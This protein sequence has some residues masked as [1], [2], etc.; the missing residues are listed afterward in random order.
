MAELRNDSGALRFAL[1]LVTRETAAA[2]PAAAGEAAGAPAGPPGR[3]LA[4]AG[5]DYLD[6]RD[7]EWWP[8]V[9][10][11][12]AWLGEAAARQLLDELAQLLRGARGG[13]AW[14]PADQAGFAVQ[15][16]AEQ[17]GAVLEVGIDLGAFLADAAGVTWRPEA[18]LALFRFR[19][20]QADLVRF[21]DALAR[22]LEA[23]GR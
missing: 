3:L 15:V 22:E 23:T 19:A 17:G 10:L 5:L 6:R 16:G 9:R 8:L 11:P 2:A 7:G 13:F 12:P 1:E 21:S 18:E 20:G 14:R 4:T